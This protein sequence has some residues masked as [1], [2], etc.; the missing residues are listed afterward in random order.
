LIL[1]AASDASY[2]EAVLGVEIA[3]VFSREI[4][5]PSSVEVWQV[6]SALC[7]KTGLESQATAREAA[8]K[9]IDFLL[10]LSGSLDKE[11]ALITFMGIEEE[12]ATATD[13][14]TSLHYFG[15]RGIGEIESLDLPVLVVYG[16]PSPPPWQV[17]RQAMALHGD[18]KPIDP[19][20]TKID[21]IWVPNDE[22]VQQ[23]LHPMR[24]RELYQACFRI[25]PLSPSDYPK[26]IIVFSPLEI[27]HL[28]PKYVV[29]RLP[30]SRTMTAFVDVA[31][32]FR[33]LKGRERT[34]AAKVARLGGC[35]PSTAKRYID[36]LSRNPTGH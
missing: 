11:R 8:I 3:E 13:A 27:P 23:Q 18:G 30:N 15:L 36:A 14:T 16:T 31:R 24:S 5:L 4:L 35:D 34:T 28:K 7:G 22:R 17:V 33:Q 9:K 25:R 26:T 29:T 21:R 10:A 6:T 12:I 20:A 32:V 2:Y 19:K 1:D